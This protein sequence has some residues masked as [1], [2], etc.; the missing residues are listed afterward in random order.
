VKVKTKVGRSRRTVSL[1]EL[2]LL[3][4][5]FDITDDVKIDE[6]T[7]H[8]AFDSIDELA[9]GLAGRIKKSLGMPDGEE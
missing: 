6:A 1:H 4:S 3:R 7:G 8:P 9:K 2:K 5:Y